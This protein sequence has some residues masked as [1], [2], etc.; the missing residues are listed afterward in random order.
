MARQQDNGT[1]PRFARLCE[2]VAAALIA[3]FSPRFDQHE[4]EERLASAP[5]PDRVMVS[6]LA[7]AG[8]F[9]AALFAASFGPFGLGLY[10]LAVILLVR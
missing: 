6:T 9:V 7:I 4:I 8:L 3:G 5:M 1:I 10:L 2:R